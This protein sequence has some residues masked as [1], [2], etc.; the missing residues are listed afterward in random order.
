MCIKPQY[1]DT[2]IKWLFGLFRNISPFAMPE[3]DSDV[4]L[5]NMTRG[6][7]I[8]CLVKNEQEGE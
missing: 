3:K 4:Y 5:C 7:Q 1:F 2:K 8:G 6:R